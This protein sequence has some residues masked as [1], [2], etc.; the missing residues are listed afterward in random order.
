MSGEHSTQHSVHDNTPHTDPVCGMTVTPAEAADV[1]EH[2]GVKY[3]FCGI[4]CAKKFRQSPGQYLD[5]SRAPAEPA[6]AEAIYTCPMHPE[7][8]QKGPGSCPK[9]GMAL[10]PEGV[11][12]S[13]QPDPELLD[14]T[15]RFWVAAALTAPLLVLAMGHMVGW[16]PLAPRVRMWV[17]LALATPV[18]WWC[19]WPLL[20]KGWRSLAGWNLNM[21]TL[22]SIGVLASWGYSVVATAAPQLFPESFRG[23][24]GQIGVYFE[25]AAVI[26]TLVLLGQMLEGRAR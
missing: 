19:G 24:G 21:F 14:M 10:E 2:E 12:A 6:D 4:G 26:T 22:I 7:V 20:V 11:D 1:V 13:D 5:K 3:Y 25:A 16:A 9:C 17:E 23:H 18:V 15:R 8:R